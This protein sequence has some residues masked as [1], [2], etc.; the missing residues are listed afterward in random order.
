MR[1]TLRQIGISH[2]TF[3]EWYKRYQMNGY[4]GLARQ[5]RNPKWFL[6][7]I[8]EWEKQ[9]VVE[10]AREYPEK[11]CRKVAFHITDKE[12]YI[13]SESSAY[14]ILKSHDLVISPVNDLSQRSLRTSR[15]PGQ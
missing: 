2:S 13:I 10:I 9:R 1:K 7:A 3:Y 11:S 15:Y 4:I 6:N 5:H 14:S 12:G 8:P